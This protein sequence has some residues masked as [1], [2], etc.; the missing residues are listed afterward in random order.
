MTP[1]GRGILTGITEVDDPLI[2]S[3][4]DKM[5]SAAS[6]RDLHQTVVD[7][8]TLITALCGALGECSN[9]S[10]QDVLDCVMAR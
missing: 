8:A 1:L 7:L 4:M 3:A 10:T 9:T 5:L 2:N 6:A